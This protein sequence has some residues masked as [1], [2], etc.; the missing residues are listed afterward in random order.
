MKEE[1]YLAQG[2]CTNCGRRNYPQWGKYKKGIPLQNYPCPK[3]G[4]M[5]W[6]PDDTLE[7]KEQ[8]EN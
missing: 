8:L 6:I 4:L 7:K 5:T 3:C 1:T 2:K